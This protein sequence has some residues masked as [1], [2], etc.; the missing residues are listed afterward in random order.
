MTARALLALAAMATWVACDSPERPSGQQPSET[1]PPS[2]VQLS[3]LIPT[4]TLARALGSAATTALASSQAIEELAYI[5]L[6]PGSAPGGQVA[7]IQR[8]GAEVAAVTSIRDGGFDPVAIVAAAEDL[9]R[10]VVRNGSGA[11]IFSQT[12]ALRP[13]RPPGVVRT[14]PPRR[15][16]DVAINASIVVVFSE[17]VAP[18][19]VT[20]ETVQLYLA[21]KP[22]AGQARVLPGT[23]SSV[24]FTPDAPL[25]PNSE[26]AIVVRRG[27]TDLEGD[28]L[29]A[30]AVVP[31]RTGTS[32]TGPANVI[33]VRPDTVF[34]HG[35][36]YQLTA[37]VFD[38]ARNVLVNQPV[39]WSAFGAGGLTVSQTGL[40][41][42]SAEGSYMVS[43]RVGE[44]I[45]TAMVYVSF[46]AG[47]ATAEIAPNPVGVP[48]GDTVLLTASL[49]DASGRWLR[50]D[51]IWTS[52]DPA[53]ARVEPKDTVIQGESTPRFHS[54]L[55]A[56]N[57]GPATITVS[58]GSASRTATVTVSAPVPVAS[59]ALD[60]ANA[61]L[62]LGA[63]VK[64]RARIRDATGRLISRPIVWTTDNESVATVDANGLV[65]AVGVGSAR[66]TASAAGVSTSAAIDVSTVDLGSVSTG[67]GH[68]C[69]LDPQ[70]GTYCWGG[71][72]AM[73]PDG[74]SAV[75]SPVRLATDLRFV[76]L[77][78]GV[79][80]SCGLT[81][82]GAAYCWGYNGGRLG[83]GPGPN[84]IATPVAV[85]GGHRFIAL[86]AGTFHVCGITTEARAFC[87][88]ANDA[89]QLGNGQSGNVST[90]PVAVGGT[91]TFA[92]ISAGDAHTCAVTSAGAAYCWGAN[93]SGQLGTGTASLRSTAPIAVT[94]SQSW[95]MVT[96]GWNH[97]CGVTT[98]GVA[99]CWGE[100]YWGQLGDGLGAATQSTNPTPTRVTGD[101]RW[102]AAMTAG[103]AFTCGLTTS[104]AA[105]CWGNGFSGQLGDGADTNGRFSPDPAP[106]A[107][108][109]T[110]SSID[111]GRFHACAVAASRVYCWGLN[112][113]GQLGTSSLTNSNVPRRVVGQP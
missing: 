53:V 96:A 100:N 77:T 41:T 2:G 39:T 70:G 74:S 94:G 56:A 66:V 79:D 80:F 29:E 106:V 109:L 57:P 30:E 20:S 34:L 59:M 38:G 101:L 112:S 97:N 31:F 75:P 47:A 107:G 24:A 46:D 61:G 18:A 104:G 16:T 52:S 22:V 7:T 105:Y 85:S 37:T 82:S 49:R 23:V 92:S 21:G 102:A 81:A 40:L 83:A 14:Y 42:A 60:P 62:L 86:S 10:V 19:S 111:A 78:S 12:V 87:W 28:A 35:S 63:N 48:A 64:L 11:E 17:P 73:L 93:T 84:F 13:T 88:G 9:V 67:G 33:E 72:P 99:Y 8:V 50:R 25:A 27:V 5:S 103:E 1:T 32:T 36:T 71:W 91:E 110:F 54:F 113:V 44:V 4:A 26:Y 98:A 95:A 15:K 6:P 43:A 90:V 108:D 69:A 55:I 3:D 45:G 89:G 76:S 51:V 58:A 65:T 68:T